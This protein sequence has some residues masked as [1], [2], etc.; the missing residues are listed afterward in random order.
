MPFPD[1]TPEDNDSLERLAA[2]LTENFPEQPMIA[3]QIMG[4]CIAVIIVELSNNQVDALNMVDAYARDLRH[5]V[6]MD[7]RWDTNRG[8]TQ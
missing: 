2:F 4:T 3:A 1:L 8:A 6:A 7:E 5:A